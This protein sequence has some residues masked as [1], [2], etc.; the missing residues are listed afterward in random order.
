MLIMTPFFCYR[1]VSGVWIPCR[2]TWSHWQ[3]ETR[4][5]HP[6][7]APAVAMA[8]GHCDQLALLRVIPEKPKCDPAGLAQE[9]R[10][11]LPASGSD[12]LQE[13]GTGATRL[14]AGREGEDLLSVWG[15]G[16]HPVWQARLHPVRHHRQ[17]LRA[18]GE[19]HVHLS[20]LPAPC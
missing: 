3:V 16:G 15:H 9:R 1:N 6:A 17:V 7:P 13:P 4:H 10:H 12:P 2:V 14:R 8:A 19:D 11:E 5:V 20:Q 18:R